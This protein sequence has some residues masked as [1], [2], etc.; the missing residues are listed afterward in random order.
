MIPSQTPGQQPY[1][2]G[3]S[4]SSAAQALRIQDALRRQL[5]ASADGVV[6]SALSDNRIQLSG[7]A[8]SEQ[9]RQ[10]IEQVAHSAATD[11]VIVNSINVA[12]PPYPPKGAKSEPPP[13]LQVLLP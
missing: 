8:G 1:P 13:E 12:N 2:F 7:T 3:T 5:P 9:E 10:R 4:S 11:Q 6:V